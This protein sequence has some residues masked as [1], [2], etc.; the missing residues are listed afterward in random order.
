VDTEAVGWTDWIDGLHNM[1]TTLF[2]DA[3]ARGANFREA[4]LAMKMF[5][6]M[7]GAYLSHLSSDPARPAFLPSAGYYS[8]YGSPNPDTVYRSAVVDDAGHYLI[9]GRRGTASDVTIMAFG[10]PT[11][12]G[13]ETFMPFDLAALALEDDGRFEVV[14][15]RERPAAVRNWW[16][17]ELG[18]RSLMLRSV[19]SDWAAHPDPDLAIVRLDGHPRRQRPDSDTLRQRASS[20]AYVVE[21]MIKSGIN[22][23][24]Q[25]RTDE[26][27]NRVV[28]VDYSGGGGLHDQW[29]Q[30]GCFE[31]EDD[32][33]LLIEVHVLETCRGFSLSLT[34]AFFS[35]LDWA[36]AQSSLNDLQAALDS[37]G[38]L[39]FVVGSKDPGVQNWLDT[40]GHQFGVLQFRWLGG[41]EAPRVVVEKVSSALTSGAGFPR[42]MARVTVPERAAAIRKRQIGAQ[43]RS[44]W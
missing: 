43:L 31:L 17:L 34:D 3:R 28:T 8:M 32:E 41:G 23:V 37:D 35:T 42:S 11:P 30:E 9:T 13:L 16:Q 36:N 21:A 6:T 27:V 25:L 38:V 10:G 26:I 18:T 4:D 15:S 24:V 5:G 22:R 7:M 14:L 40:I 20:F 29:Y 33:A 2:E 44:L 39:R 1:A 12:K 19:S